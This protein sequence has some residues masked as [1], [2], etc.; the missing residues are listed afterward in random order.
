MP[1]LRGLE[2]LKAFVEGGSVSAAADRVR[3]SQP[4]VGR[5]LAALE[6]EIGFPLFVRKGQRLLLTSEGRQFY[7]EADRV[8]TGHRALDRFAES[9][10]K[11]SRSHI[12]VLS[13]PYVTSSL[14]LGPIAQMALEAP[15]FTAALDVRVRLDLETWVTQEMFDLGLAA[16]PP[17]H[18]AIE[19]EPLIEIDAVACMHYRHP[20]ASKAVIGV[21]DL[22][23]EPLV[24]A[25]TRSV[26]RTA[27][28]Q[29]FY[30]RGKTMN[31]RFEATNGLN[32][33]QLAARGLGIS[34]SDAYVAQSSNAP[35]MVVRRF[36]PAI[37][38][39]YGLLFPVWQS[40]T[41]AVVRLADLI[42]AN[43][44]KQYAQIQLVLDGDGRFA[45]A[46]GPD[47]PSG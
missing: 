31:V 40:R 47:H 39:A 34:I 2:A 36:R 12:R 16:V 35:D 28:E 6:A 33:A 25:H 10:K 3:R 15:E 44:Q 4:Q 20:L 27:L 19:V 37:K 32:G 22:E 46:H 5:L 21:E 45:S 1:N 38:V 17:Q 11:R 30:E 43:I 14:I 13:A 26:V 42:R 29:K 8:L 7:V 9:V 18:P 23:H 24:L 41:P